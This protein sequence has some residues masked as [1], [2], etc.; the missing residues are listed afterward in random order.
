[1]CCLLLLSQ[2]A[3]LTPLIIKWF[4]IRRIQFAETLLNSPDLGIIADFLWYL[5]IKDICGCKLLFYI[6]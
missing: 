1:M 3:K 6:L 2:R 5:K 4:S